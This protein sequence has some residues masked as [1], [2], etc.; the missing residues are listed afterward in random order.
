MH[1]QLCIV[2]EEETRL[3]GSTLEYAA[4]S[5]VVNR[6][7]FSRTCECNSSNS[8][9]HSKNV[10]RHKSLLTDGTDTRHCYIVKYKAYSTRTTA[11]LL[12]ACYEKVQM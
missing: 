1:I 12:E 4:D 11:S 3:M 5:F 2:H 7:A 9:R 8:L 6:S 10:L